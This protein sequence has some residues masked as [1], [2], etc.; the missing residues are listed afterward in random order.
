MSEIKAPLK[1]QLTHAEFYK[2]ARWMEQHKTAIEGQT[3]E[4]ILKQV[5]AEIEFPITDTHIRTTAKTVGIKLGN[6]PHK[7]GNPKG[8]KVIAQ[9]VVGLYLQL[10][11]D[12]P[13]DLLEISGSPQAQLR[14]HT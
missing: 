4:R 13:E 5:R 9:A 12:I 11:V 2:L 1:C 14:K 8:T 3:V 6:A 7:G 10:G